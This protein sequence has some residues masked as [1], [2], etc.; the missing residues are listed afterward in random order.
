MSINIAQK[1]GKD[2][3]INMMVPKMTNKQQNRWH[4]P[5]PRERTLNIHNTLSQSQ[6]THCQSWLGGG[7]CA[8]IF[9]ENLNSRHSESSDAEWHAACWAITERV[10]W[11]R[12]HTPNEGF[13]DWLHAK[14]AASTGSVPALSLSHSLTPPLL[15]GKRTRVGCWALV[16]RER[17]RGREIPPSHWETCELYRWR[18]L[19]WLWWR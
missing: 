2:S 3:F 18:W 19:W 9:P 14:L 15:G 10:A 12:S 13:P 16:V 8:K 1:I 5:T 17:E 6:E 4:L 7:L 11:E